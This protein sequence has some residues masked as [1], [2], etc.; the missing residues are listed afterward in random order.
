MFKPQCRGSGSQHNLKI[1]G[2]LIRFAV[3]VNLAVVTLCAQP[4]DFPRARPSEIGLTPDRLDAITEMLE[5]EIQT[6]RIS[7]AV[8][9]LSR[10]GK[11]GYFEAL[12]MRD[13]AA[14]A[15]MKVRY[16][17]SHRFD[18]QGRHQCKR[19]ETCG[20]GHAIAR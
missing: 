20:R 3:L 18:D 4:T 10:D 17:L 2:W 13:V 16:Y 11:L 6:C 7:G 8:A 12:G 5:R 1:A 15:P 9:A 19:H 14:A